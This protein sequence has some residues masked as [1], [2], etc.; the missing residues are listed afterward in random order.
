MTSVAVFN[1]SIKPSAV[2]SNTAISAITSAEPLSAEIARCDIEGHLPIGHRARAAG[3][4]TAVNEQRTRR[5]A[6]RRIRHLD[7]QRDADD[8]DA[9][10]IRIIAAGR[11]LIGSPR[12]IGELFFG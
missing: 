7:A 11:R 3:G 1:T 2:S 5:P 9:E 12:S 6:V 8:P 4:R 10:Q